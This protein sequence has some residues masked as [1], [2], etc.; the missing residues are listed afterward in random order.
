MGFADVIDNVRQASGSATKLRIEA[1]CFSANSTT[2]TIPTRLSHVVG[3]MIVGCVTTK[4][5]CGVPLIGSV[6]EGGFVC[7]TMSDAHDGC[8]PYIVAGW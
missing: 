2:A 1:G 5:C 7:F 3:G 4:Q 6:C 8:S